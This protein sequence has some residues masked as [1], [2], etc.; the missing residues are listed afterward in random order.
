MSCLQ[1]SIWTLWVGKGNFEDHGIKGDVEQIVL[2]VAEKRE[3]DPID[4]VKVEGGEKEQ[5]EHCIQRPI[6]ETD[7]REDKTIQTDIR[8][9][10]YGSGPIKLLGYL[11]V[12]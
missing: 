2:Q 10:D 3:A 7:H 11:K 9:V 1:S 6:W 12:V 8:P 4:T 5:H